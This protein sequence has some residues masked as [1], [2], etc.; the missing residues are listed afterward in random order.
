ML[1]YESFNQTFISHCWEN[2]SYSNLSKDSFI[3]PFPGREGKMLLPSANANFIKR[4]LS[5]LEEWG[6]G[7]VFL[8]PY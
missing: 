1:I 4:E 6:E 7:Y 8:H 3:C 2:H 5:R